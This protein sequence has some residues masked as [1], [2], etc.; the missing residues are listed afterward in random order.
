MEQIVRPRFI[1]FHDARR[2]SDMI[3]QAMLRMNFRMDSYLS[4]HRGFILLVA[5]SEVPRPPP[6]R[7]QIAPAVR[8]Q[9]KYLNLTRRC[10]A[11]R[12]IAESE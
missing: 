11:L 8:F 2:D 5:D 12:R 9:S 7:G 10:P 6:G 1:A 4:T 3:Y